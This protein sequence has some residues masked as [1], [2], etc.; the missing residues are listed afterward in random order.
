MKLRTGFVSNSSS[1]SFIITL[2]DKVSRYSLED[3]R[4]LMEDEGFDP[5]KQLYEDLTRQE[6]EKPTFDAWEK[7]RYGLNKLDDNQY[8]V[9]YGNEVC[10]TGNYNTDYEMETFL[11]EKADDLEEINI[12]CFSNH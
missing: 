5:I 11:E 1:S 2:P 12:R 6:N 8:L 7:K 4:E 3:F 9:E 10:N